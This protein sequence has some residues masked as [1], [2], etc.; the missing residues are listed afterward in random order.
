MFLVSILS[1]GKLVTNQNFFWLLLTFFYFLFLHFYFGVL[2][3]FV[4]LCIF[5]SWGLQSLLLHILMSSFKIV[6]FI[7]SNIA[8]VSLSLLT[9]PENPITCL[10]DLFSMFHIY[11]IFIFVS[12]TQILLHSLVLMFHIDLYLGLLIHLIFC[13]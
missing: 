6:M 4:L 9:S 13:M 3:I 2:G 5:P 10:L 12:P 1:F 8:S 7:T 11:F